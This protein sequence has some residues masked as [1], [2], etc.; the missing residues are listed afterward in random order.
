[1][2][3]NF[4][5]RLL[6]TLIALA[7]MTSVGLSGFYSGAQNT[8][9]PTATPAPITVE[10][11]S[12]P[13]PVVDDW[14]SI[15]GCDLA[16]AKVE[17][18]QIPAD[19]S[20]PSSYENGN[21]HEVWELFVFGDKSS[22][23]WID[24]DSLNDRWGNPITTV[25]ANATLD[26]IPQSALTVWVFN[27]YGHLAAR[28]DSRP[29]LEVSGFC[30]KVDG[31]VSWASD[32]ELTSIGVYS[33]EYP[34][35]QVKNWYES[36]FTVEIFTGKKLSHSDMSIIDFQIRGTNQGTGWAGL[37]YIGPSTST[38]GIFDLDDQNQMIWEFQWADPD[39]DISEF[40]GINLP[41]DTEIIIKTTYA[42]GTIN[43]QRFVL[44]PGNFTRPTMIEPV[45]QPI[46]PAPVSEVNS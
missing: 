25:N 33:F 18:A 23:N 42:S 41:L 21:I 10:P 32:E 2:S 13:T 34:T 24:V 43:L 19:S 22:I 9:H 46:S 16:Y 27:K 14:Q 26:D 35:D 36:G 37:G 4:A 12:I 44:I 30:H 38:H 20:H 7:L 40:T 5:R 11:T 3:Q 28:D 29:D 45:D 39:Y 1:M 17:I 15:R 31:E 8:Y 6:M